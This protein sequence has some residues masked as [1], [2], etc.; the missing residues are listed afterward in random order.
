MADTCIVLIGVLLITGMLHGFS[1]AFV[2]VTNAF[3]LGTSGGVFFTRFIKYLPY[4]GNHISLP[5]SGMIRQ[6]GILMS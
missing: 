3:K 5:V 1:T 2:W 4:P 6:A